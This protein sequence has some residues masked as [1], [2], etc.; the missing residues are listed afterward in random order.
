VRRT[1]PRSTEIESPE[2]VTL[3]FHVSLYKVE[4]TK[5]VFARNLFSKN[6]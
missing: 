2:G 4:P 3:S 1:E 6:R 5:A